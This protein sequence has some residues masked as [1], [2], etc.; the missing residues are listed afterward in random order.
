MKKSERIAA[1]ERN[2]KRLEDTVLRQS[3]DIDFLI[4]FIKADRITQDHLLEGYLAAREMAAK[5]KRDMEDTMFRV[6]AWSHLNS[7]TGLTPG[8][9]HGQS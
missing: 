5:L 2:V 4:Q 9:S 8:A 3:A 7:F 6:S 1:P